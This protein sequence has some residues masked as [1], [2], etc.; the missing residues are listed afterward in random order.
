MQ[1]ISRI[2]HK[3]LPRGQRAYWMYCSLIADAAG[4]QQWCATEPRGIGSP[5]VWAEALSRQS[6]LSRTASQSHL[7]STLSLNNRM[8]LKSGQPKLA[9]VTSHMLPSG[10][11]ECRSV[12]YFG[13]S[14]LL[15]SYRACD[16]SRDW[17]MKDQ[18]SLS[19]HTIGHWESFVWEQFTALILGDMH[20][21]VQ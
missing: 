20:V 13:V 12:S 10:V 4:G 14:W 8:P 6:L 17:K 19:C 3:V 21:N 18:Q 9:R 7:R 2:Q 5:G 1:L 15:W 16:F 11:G